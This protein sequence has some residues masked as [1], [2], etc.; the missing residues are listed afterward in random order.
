MF[1]MDVLEKGCGQHG[2]DVLQKDPCCR[3]LPECR[4]PGRLKQTGVCEGLLGKVV[5]SIISS[6]PRCFLHPLFLATSISSP[7]CLLGYSCITSGKDKIKLISRIQM[8]P[9]VKF[10]LDYSLRS[11]KETDHGV[12]RI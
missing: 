8:L 4:L 9:S 6:L 2:G 11:P 12:R 5:S 10:E 1:D 3:V 7:L